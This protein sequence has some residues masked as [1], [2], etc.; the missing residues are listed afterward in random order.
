MSGPVSERYRGQ[1][2]SLL[3]K[4]GKE[5]A[6]GPALRE[7][8]CVLHV[9]SGF[10]TDELGT[11]T[12]E[13]PRRGTQLEAAREKARLALAKG[14]ARLGLGS[15]GAFTPGPMGLFAWNV[16]L[17]VL[18]DAEL[19]IEIVGRAEGPGHHL[20]ATVRSESELVAFASRA[21]FPEH[22]LV[23]R[24][25]D[26]RGKP[27]AQGGDDGA[28]LTRA[29][30]TAAERSTGGAVFVESDLRAHRNPTRMARIAEAGRDLAARMSQTCPRCAAPGFGRA[31]RLPG[32]PCADC[33]APT[34]AAQAERWDCVRCGASETRALSPGERADPACCPYCNP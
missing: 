21:L 27:V 20:H 24:P 10:D 25:D 8:G 26:E 18:L 16:E 30:R 7:I 34:S 9:V 15:E 22:G 11:F 4:H 17:V 6:L 12:R 31:A 3:T 29:F 33:G 32:L 28:A 19:G 2:V 1:R 5:A 14:G 13:I 23:V